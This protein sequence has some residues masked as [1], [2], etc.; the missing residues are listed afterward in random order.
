MAELICYQSGFRPAVSLSSSHDA[1]AH[2][3]V[4]HYRTIPR[5]SDDSESEP[6]THVSASA[7]L[8][9]KPFAKHPS[10]MRP[11]RLAF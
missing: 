10:D 4:P 11:T 3:F 6:S 2:D 7:S 8:R 1:S 9:L 5:Y